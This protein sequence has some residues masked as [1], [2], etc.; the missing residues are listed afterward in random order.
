MATIAHPSA[1][2]SATL[3][4]HLANRPGAFASLAA[5]VANHDALLDAIDLVRVE[6]GM[7]V[8]D[9]T[10]LA[11]DAEHIGRIVETARDA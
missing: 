4:V 11:S 5:A 10:I 2:F 3:R 8:R 7:K 9:V 1:Q 6:N